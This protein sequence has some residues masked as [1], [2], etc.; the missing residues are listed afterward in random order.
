MGK[1][2]LYVGICV[3]M[4]LCPILGVAALFLVER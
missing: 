3:L 1:L 2:L 4:Y